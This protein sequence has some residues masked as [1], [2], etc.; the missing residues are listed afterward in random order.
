[1]HLFVLPFGNPTTSRFSFP[2]LRHS[3]HELLEVVLRTR[4][5]LVA[6]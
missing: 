4:K 1:M 2:A 3:S 5:G 6:L